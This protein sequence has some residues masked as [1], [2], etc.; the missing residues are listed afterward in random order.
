MRRRTIWII[1]GALATSLVVAGSGAA[2]ATADD[3]ASET[4]IT[5]P[6]L[7]TASDAALAETGQGRVTGTEVGDEEGYY[8]VEVTLADGREVDVHL[9]AD[10][11]V[12]GTEPEDADEDGTD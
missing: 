8:E 7:A 9:D 1:G 10:F 2:V 12:T 3:D 5:G 11:V 6:A 4:A